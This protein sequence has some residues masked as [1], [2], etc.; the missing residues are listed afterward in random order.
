MVLMMVILLLLCRKKNSSDN[1]LFSDIG[2]R[3]SE[4]ATE[5]QPAAAPWSGSFLSVSERRLAGRPEPLWRPVGEESSIM[6]S[7]SSEDSKLPQEESS[8]PSPR[9]LRA[10]QAAMNDSSDEEVDQIENGGSVAPCTMLAIQ[11]ALAEQ[12]EGPVEKATLISRSSASQVVLSSSEEEPEPNNVN[13]LPH[14]DLDSKRNPTGPSICVKDSF[15]ASS[16]EDEME[17][18]IGQRNE[19]LQ[20]AL[21][22]PPH[23]TK[24]KSNEETMKGQSIEDIKTGRSGWTE[25]Q[26]EL[27][28]KVPHSPRIC[29]QPLDVDAVMFEPGTNK[30]T[31]VPEEMVNVNS[32]AS[33]ESESEGTVISSYQ[34]RKK[35]HSI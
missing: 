23:E 17:E 1:F 33:E 32:E 27:E 4:T 26:E 14:D 9:T 11:H 34:R 20:L 21:L 31:E 29:G 3:K 8:P 22:K 7:P 35:K 13:T 5:S 15:L 2:T 19:D 30:S 24:M 10:I 25:K 28:K 12:E 16:S 6:S 18:M